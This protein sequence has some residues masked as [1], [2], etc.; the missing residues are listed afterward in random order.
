MKLT[1]KFVTAFLAGL[2]AVLAVYAYLVFRW[3][4]ELFQRD[5][6]RN[7]QVTGPVL[8]DAVRS[9]WERSGEVAARAAVRQAN[10]RDDSFRIRWVWPDAPAESADGPRVGPQA[11]AAVRDGAAVFLSGQHEGGAGRL[12][13][14]F[15]VRLSD[16]R[17]GA[18]ELAEALDRQRH[19]TL[20]A[21]LS[22]GV[23]TTAIIALSGVLAL[24]V[25]MRFVGR[26]IEGLIDSIRH[27]AQGDL[28]QHPSVAQRDE[29][30]E[31]AAEFGVMCDEL[32]EA[33]TRLGTETARRIQ[34]LEELRLADRLRIVGQLTAG[35]AHELGTPLNVVWARAKMIASGEVQ[36]EAVGDSARV[37]VEQAQRMKGIIRELLDF[38]RPRPPTR[39]QVDLLRI[40]G[41][42]FQLLGSVARKHG[43]SLEL[44]EGSGPVV[45]AVDTD[46]MQQVL[47]NL[48]VN[49]IQAMPRGG[50][51]VV[52]AGL[53]RVRPPADHGGAEDA[54]LCLSV[55]DQGQGIA[56]ADL[57]RIFE[58]FF[59]TKDIGVGTGLGLSVSR[60]IVLE[61][62]G[63]IAVQSRPG[64]GSRFSV[65]L[66]RGIATCVDAC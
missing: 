7:A 54:Y 55:S 13:S 11:I 56:D 26:P 10:Q 52:Q 64:A 46:Q 22:I 39:V 8:A 63:W 25:G 49:A 35:I 59:T 65:Y 30:G 15:P 3:D 58:P 66:P 23:A 31:L 47:T 28:R 17:T 36:G 37:V 60:G 40:V 61:H 20:R 12:Y 6:Q 44:R 48:V 2:V 57:P 32:E 29:L 38:A 24:F 41:Q 21:L 16:G 50:Q 18:L 19:H 14:Y 43:V 27:V 34:A 62:G 45:A 9:A 5:M 4:T 53:E 42:T 51:V 1:L 33:H